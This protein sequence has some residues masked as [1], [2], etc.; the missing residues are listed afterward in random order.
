MAKKSAKQMRDEKRAEYVSLLMDMLAQEDVGLCASNK[1]NMP[2]VL[3]DGTEAFVLVTVSVPTGGKDDEY[4]GYG[5][6]ESYEM[7]LAEKAE[8]KVSR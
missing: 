1:F 4:D 3:E 6:R 7:K 8:K 2:I 5:E